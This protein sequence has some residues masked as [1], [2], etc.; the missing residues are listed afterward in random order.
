MFFFTTKRE[1]VNLPS[2]PLKF[3]FCLWKALRSSGFLVAPYLFRIF[4]LEGFPFYYLPSSCVHSISPFCTHSFLRGEGGIFFFVPSLVRVT[5]GLRDR[6]ERVEIICLFGNNHEG[7]YF[8]KH[9]NK[10]E[11]LDPESAI[12][13]EAQGETNLTYLT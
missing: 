9:N 8:E 2:S 12:D 3:I 13:G 4:I 7:F 1:Y 6:I 10:T 5:N 11:N